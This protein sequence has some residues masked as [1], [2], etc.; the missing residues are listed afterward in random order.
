MRP[1]PAPLLLIKVSFDGRVAAVTV[2]GEVDIL[3][4]PGLTEC[5]LNVAAAHPQRLVLDLTAVTFLDV[6]A[7][8]AI[9]QARDTYGSACQVVLRKPRPS[10]RKVLR[11]TGVIAD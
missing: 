10:A 8:R 9:A 4:V 5:L 2:A 11:L 1:D 7:A 6:A 3:T